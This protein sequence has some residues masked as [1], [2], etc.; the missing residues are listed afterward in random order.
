MLKIKN[1]HS[2]FLFPLLAI[3][4]AF[5]SK[6]INGQTVDAKNKVIRKIPTE[7]NQGVA[8]DADYY[9][10]ISNLKITKHNKVTTK[11]VATW[12]ADTNIKAFEHFKHMNSGTVIDGKLYVA[13]SRYKTDPNNNTIEIWNV[14]NRLLVHEKTVP[15][16]RKYGSLTWVDKTPDGFWWMCYAVYGAGLNK[17][18]KLVKYKFKD[19]KFI[20]IKSWYFPDEVIKNWGKMS[21][22]G[23]SWGPDGKLYTTGHDHA[24][25]FV[26]EVDE[27]GNLKLVR[28]ETNLGF[29]G[30][31][32]AWDRFAVQPALWGIVKREFVTVAIVTEK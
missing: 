5:T 17:N 23:G 11:L 1:R 24:K 26:L 27:K 20:E 30:Q 19:N 21:C 22:S 31:A 2:F 10:A 16:P 6:G 25:A 14:K 32:I 18:T 28:I 3:V 4:F 15:M 9:Y 29:R 8:V 7:A 13:H 12:Q